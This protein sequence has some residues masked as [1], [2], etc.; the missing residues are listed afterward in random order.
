ME[1]A[2]GQPGFDGAGL[3]PGFPGSSGAPPGFPSLPGQAIPGLPGLPGGKLFLTKQL[4][5]NVRCM[6]YSEKLGR[7]I[8][9]KMTQKLAFESINR[10]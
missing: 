6:F 9:T 3:P 8:F 10:S 4:G 1:F 7:P 5:Q 2:W